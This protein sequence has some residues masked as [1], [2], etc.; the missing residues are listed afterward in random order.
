MTREG[1]DWATNEEVVQVGNAKEV[2]A[3]YYGIGLIGYGD[4]SADG[5][6][7]GW[8]EGAFRSS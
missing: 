8:V 3:T 6:S 5:A 1:S 4:V 2:G 7:R